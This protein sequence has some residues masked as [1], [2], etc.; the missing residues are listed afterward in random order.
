MTLS[1]A[2]L[3]PNPDDMAFEGRWSEVRDRMAGPLARQGV[4]V[5]SVAWT[6]ATVD[7][8][9]FDLVL[10]LTVWGYHR[11]HAWW[12]DSVAGWEAAGVRL[13][14]PPSVLAW[15]S[16]KRYLARLFEQGAPVVPTLF[17]DSL[18]GLDWEETARGLGAGRLIAKPRISA[19]AYK[20]VRFTPGQP[21]GDDAPSGPALI[22]PYLDAVE[23]EGEMS[24]I[25]FEGRFSHAIRK[26]AAAGDFR[27]QPEWGGQIQAYDPA[28]EVLE[29]A[30][31]I[32]YAVEEPLLYARVDL[33]RDAERRP[34]LMELELVEPDLYLGFDPERGARFV[35]AVRRTAERG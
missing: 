21:L 8:A 20:T 14:N 22:Q 12:L 29:A 31:Q 26:V 9:S 3:T 30:E 11:D 10:P 24:L 5:E 1:V 34:V 13:R 2:I 28:P 25:F 18:D 32:L 35:D 19:S 4:S 23:G 27:T 15:N 33:V 16:D 7:L 6:D 17:V